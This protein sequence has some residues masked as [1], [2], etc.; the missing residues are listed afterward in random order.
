T[1]TA[2]QKWQYGLMLASKH[3][4][5]SPAE[6][7]MKEAGANSP[8]LLIRNR[9]RL[10]IEIVSATG[11]TFTASFT[12][13][14]DAESPLA[15]HVAKF[16]DAATERVPNEHTEQFKLY[17]NRLLIEILQHCHG[18]LLAVHVRNE[19][20]TCPEKLKSGV[21]LA[22]PLVLV[23]AYIAAIRG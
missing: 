16:V 4:A 21:W 14:Q 8:V 12:S 20:D 6:E 22:N 15:E 17:L 10:L 7:V 5:A 11:E 3:S 13:E 1:T 23:D 19:H 2:P 9:G 18:T